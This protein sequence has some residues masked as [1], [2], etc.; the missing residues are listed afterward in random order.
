MYTR[1]PG[2]ESVHVV[3]AELL[4]H[5]KG[6]VKCGRCGQK[7]DA[8]A[9][10]FDEW[11]AAGAVPPAAGKRYRP[12]VLGSS[13]DLSAPFGP[14]STRPAQPGRRRTAWLAALTLL[15]AL[16]LL[17]AAWTFR[18]EL[19]AVPGARAQLARWQLV[20][21]LPEGTLRDPGRIQVVSRDLHSH[22][23][24]AGML[25]LSATFVNRANAAQAWPEM[26][27]TLLGLD[28]EAVAKRRFGP[29]DYLPSQAGFSGLVGPDVHVPVLLEF[30]SPDDR[31]VGFEIAFH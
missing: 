27:L 9:S 22:P 21:A 7:F 31:A 28:G 16:T 14:A 15:I 8:L 30:A 4:A 1:C 17:N 29:E 25:V 10:L 11:P 24:R 23:T 3:N 26:E 12:P 2:C 5:S 6:S 20:D 19:L 18:E 13:Q